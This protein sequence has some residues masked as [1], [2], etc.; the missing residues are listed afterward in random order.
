MWTTIIRT[1]NKA[2][3]KNSRLPYLF[4]KYNILPFYAVSSSLNNSTI[5][6]IF[7]QFID[8]LNDNQ[9][10][11]KYIVFTLDKDLIESAQHYG[12]GYKQVFSRILTWL[13][14]NIEDALEVRKDDLCG[15][16]SRA[17]LE[18]TTLV[19][20]KMVPRPFL[21]NVEK[22]FMFAQCT[23][24]NNILQS[25]MAKFANTK[26]VSLYFPDDLNLFDA[27]GH[28]SSNGHALFWRELNCFFQSWEAPTPDNN[29]TNV[30]P[31]VQEQQRHTNHSQPDGHRAR[32]N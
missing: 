20:I 8:G 22:A 24:F 11:P 31:A 17:F 32:N 1:K 9:W 29:E 27:I 12:F 28:L 5:G 3:L 15:K 7:N 19:W 14:S 21:K 23:A 26:V 16:R 25:T 6:R 10:L 18:D 4:D 30:A 13:A 2:K